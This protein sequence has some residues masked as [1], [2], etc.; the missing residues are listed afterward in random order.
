MAEKRIPKD[1]T[2]DKINQVVQKILG[3]QQVVLFTGAGISMETES[4]IIEVR[5][6]SGM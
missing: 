6:D 5:G 4:R 1:T 2:T 3:A